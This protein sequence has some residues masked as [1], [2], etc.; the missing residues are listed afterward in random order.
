MTFPFGV[1]LDW[2]PQPI[3]FS[4]R[5][6]RYLSPFPCEQ[7]GWYGLCI[8]INQCLKHTPVFYPLIIWDFFL[9][10]W[11]FKLTLVLM[12]NLTSALSNSV[13]NWSGQVHQWFCGVPYIILI[14]VESTVPA[15]FIP[16]F[17]PPI[18]LITLSNLK[19]NITTL[20]IIILIY[21]WHYCHILLV[22]V[23]SSWNTRIV[24]C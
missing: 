15:I 5:G 9:L 11:C 14:S 12:N 6:N 20:M 16:L 1:I 21:T 18:N 2:V 4:R 22:A 17:S 8:I 24:F 23:D 19:E 7:I 13:A 3:W 10:F